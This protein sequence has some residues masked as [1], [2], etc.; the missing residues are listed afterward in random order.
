MTLFL[1]CFITKLM[2][3]RKLGEELYN[4]E[5]NEI[6]GNITN[7]ELEKIMNDI[8]D[9]FPEASSIPKQ[10][11]FDKN[12]HFKYN[13]KHIEQM[14]KQRMMLNMNNYLEESNR[15]SSFMDTY[16]ESKKEIWKPISKKYKE[17]AINSI[18]M[19]RINEFV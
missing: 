7:D 6:W 11:F 14:V 9:E 10:Y 4:S 13:K 19:S 16:W 18:K 5:I 15:L 1:S 3:Y 8:I 2:D 12:K 17:L